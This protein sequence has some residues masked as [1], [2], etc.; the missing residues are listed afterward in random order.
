MASEQQE[1]QILWTANAAH[2][3]V[4]KGNLYKNFKSV[5][6]VKGSGS[7]AFVLLAT[8]KLRFFKEILIVFCFFASKCSGNVC[9]EE[10]ILLVEDS[11]PYE[12]TIEQCLE[13]CRATNSCQVIHFL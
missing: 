13:A 8:M 5:N 9:Y 7:N 12:S 1:R 11:L 2:A 6:F 10:N 3:R 4:Q